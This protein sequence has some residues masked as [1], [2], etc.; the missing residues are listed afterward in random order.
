M[1]TGIQ[2]NH[3]KL[4]TLIIYNLC[5]VY[6]STFNI[7]N[8]GQ[9]RRADP[10]RAA[11]YFQCVMGQ[12]WML[13]LLSDALNC[14]WE[15]L[16]HFWWSQALASSPYLSSLL[17]LFGISIFLNFSNWVCNLFENCSLLPSWL[18]K[19]VFQKKKS[20]I[21]ENSNHIINRQWRKATSLCASSM[22]FFSSLWSNSLER[23]HHFHA[24]GC[25]SYGCVARSDKGFRES[26]LSVIQLGHGFS[27]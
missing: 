19:G 22:G 9:S 10:G 18:S 6:D 7:S 3:I 12:W 17:W 24:D 23:T 8:C 15:I 1:E 2:L 14:T 21:R 13:S 16:W 20:F 25:W 27:I 4:Q 5:D 11:L 26:C